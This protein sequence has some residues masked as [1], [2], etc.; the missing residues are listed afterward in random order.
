[1]AQSLEG[2]LGRKSIQ[3]APLNQPKETS[4]GED[5]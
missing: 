1:M 4:N 3:A 2:T 5:E